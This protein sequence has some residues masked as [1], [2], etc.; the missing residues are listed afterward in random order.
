MQKLAVVLL[1][2]VLLAYAP[3]VMAQGTA[4]G[5]ILARA[6]VMTPIQVTPQQNLEF[7][8]VIPGANKSIP[9]TNASAG[10]WL[11]QGTAGAEVTLQFTAL[12]AT[13][14]DGGANTMPI[15]YGAT[16]AAHHTSNNPGAAT[17]FNPIAIATANI[18]S[19]LAE[20]Y[21][22]IGGTVQPA[23]AQA[24]GLYTGTITLTATYTGN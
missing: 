1:A 8:N 13:L 5:N 20:L 12:P 18:S 2:V 22:W 19:P 7:G 10:R 9:V 6:N 21:T 14:S 23:A 11:V 17:T 24:A 16:D 4:S 3:A 15:V